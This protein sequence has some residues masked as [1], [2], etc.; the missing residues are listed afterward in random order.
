VQNGAREVDLPHLAVALPGSM[1]T[2][3]LVLLTV[4]S[5]GVVVWLASRCRRD[6]QSAAAVLIAGGVVA[7]PHS[8]PADMILVALALAVWG[9]ARWF[10]WLGL[11]VAALVCALAPVPVPVLVGVLAIGWVCLRASGL[12]T[13]PSPEPVPA[14]AR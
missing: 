7:A 3:G 14:S 11:S 12:L 8:L 10:E 6:F 9:H 5:I 4:V 13:W 1:Q 2:V